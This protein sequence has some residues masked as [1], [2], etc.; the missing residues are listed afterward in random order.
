M[1]AKQQMLLKQSLLGS[2]HRKSTW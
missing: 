1:S 2:L